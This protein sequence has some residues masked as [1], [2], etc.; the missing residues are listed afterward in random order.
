MVRGLLMGG[1][2]GLV[3]SGLVLALVSQMS[4]RRSLA[5]TAPVTAPAGV[6]DEGSAAPVET[7]PVA[8][9]GAETP[10]VPMPEVAPAPEATQ[11]PGIAVTP[12]ILPVPEQPAA[13]P[14]PTGAGADPMPAPE[15]DPAPV[16]PE[17]PARAA[18]GPTIPDLE[19]GMA[20]PLPQTPDVEARA[21]AVQSAPGAGQNAPA[22][23]GVSAVDLQIPAPDGVLRTVTSLNVPEID[24][25]YD[26]APVP[27]M[28][29]VEQAAPGLLQPLAPVVQQGESLLPATEPAPQPPAEPLVVTD[30]LPRVGDD[31][32]AIDATP[33]AAAEPVALADALRR[34]AEEFENP[35]SRPIVA[36]V[37][38]DGGGPPVDLPFAVSVAV[39][40]AAPDVTARAAAYRAAGVEV[41]VQPQ[42]PEGAL[43]SDVSVA[44]ADTFLRIP[45]AVALLDT[46]GGQFQANREVLAQVISEVSLTGH[47]LVAFPRGLNTALQVAERSDVP[48]ALV[49]RD[50]DGEGQDIKAIKRFL[51]QA[52]FRARQEDSVI[53]FARN[54]PETIVALA[55]WALGNR[56]ASVALAPVS[57]ALL[58]GR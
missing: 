46:P 38:L 35:D 27:T 18:V 8:G 23:P 31:E 1:L 21:P 36:I 25:P 28:P 44:L 54:T 2:F 34:N 58:A 39:D 51:D 47:G 40:A 4:D 42:I 52:A 33:L 56:A 24:P 13:A 22:A 16:L 17:T 3:F 37:L 55:E 53:L 10:A 9:A 15:V 26:A 48:A 29:T 50:I 11:A 32:P 7:L 12:E 41:L 45:V 30:R 14:G 43:A 19:G 20:A 49:F 5:P 57:A 6:A